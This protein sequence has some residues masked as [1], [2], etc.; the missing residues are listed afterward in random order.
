MNSTSISETEAL[1]WVA[2]IF[3]EPVERVTP[4]TARDAIAAW[5]SLGVLTLVAEL[6]SHFDI[7]IADEEIDS[8]QS[9]GD[10]IAFLRKHGKV[11]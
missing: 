9:V 7:S 2:Q 8:L 3:E 4:M 11:A 5:D 10:V 6:D 1:A